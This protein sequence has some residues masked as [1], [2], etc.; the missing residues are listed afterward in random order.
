MRRACLLLALAFVPVLAPAAWGKPKGCFTKAE[1]IAEREVRH[2]IFLREASRRCQGRFLAHSRKIWDA[3]EQDNGVRFRTQ[4]ARRASGWQREF[5]DDWKIKQTRSDG[6]IVTYARIQAVTPAFCANVDE[7]L[8]E[9]GKAGYA[10]F[11]RQAA[12]IRNEVTDDYRQCQ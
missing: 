4:V 12:R 3:F 9:N 11:A 1:L 2:G 6:Q 8:Q 10:G 7:M 5:P